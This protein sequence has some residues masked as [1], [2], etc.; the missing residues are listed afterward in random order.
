VKPFGAPTINTVPWTVP[1]A[2]G[3][4]VVV[5]HELLPLDPEPIDPEL[6]LD[7]EQH[8][9]LDDVELPLDPELPLE[10]P[11]DMEVV[12]A[13]RLPSPVRPKADASSGITVTNKT[14]LAA[15]ITA[16]RVRCFQVFMPTPF[17]LSGLI[18]IC[19]T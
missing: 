9:L 8:E 7:P 19:A 10:L 11:H 5:L 14:K 3:C 4:V 18:W 12:L 13:R 17:S 6:P 2:G 16:T 1:G 15:A